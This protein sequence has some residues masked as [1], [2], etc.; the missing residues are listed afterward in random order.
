MS[1]FRGRNPLRRFVRSRSGNFAAVAALLAVPLV[2]GAGVALDVSTI[3][4]VK[5]DLQQSLDSAALAVARKGPD[6]SERQAMEVATSFLSGNFANDYSNLKMARN[7]SSV[8]VT[9]TVNAGIAFG[10]LFGYDDVPVTVSS[11][12]DIAYT[13]YEIGLVLDTTGSMAG[14]KLRAMKGA[15]LGLIEDLSKQVSDAD[16]LKFALV[17]FATFVNVGPQYG[18]SFDDKGKIIKASAAD[19][20]DV[21]GKSTIPQLELL[22][23][24]SRFEVFHRLGREWAGCVETRQPS[25]KGAHDVADTPATRGDKAS[26]FVPAFAIDEPDD[27]GYRNSYIRSGVDPLDK[28]PRAKARKLAK[29]GLGDLLAQVGLGGFAGAAGGPGA[30]D[31]RHGKGPNDGCTVQPISPLTNDYGELKRKVDALRASGT[32]NIMEGV[33]WGMR[34]L[35]PGEPF[36]Q[37]RDDAPGVEKIMI[38]LTDGANNFGTR[39]VSLGSSYS[40]FGYLVDGRL[41]VSAGGSAVTNRLMNEKTLAACTNAKK[42]GIELYTIRLEEPDVQTGTMLKRCAS[43]REHFFD[44]PSRSQLDEVFDG[45]RDSIVRLRLSS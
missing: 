30:T 27:R 6:I 41:G 10:G 1:I 11:S 29:Y 25:K 4:R 28:S 24:I 36:T 31:Y 42:D 33:A 5:S 17:P 15:V 21:E 16:K 18:P 37:G 35:S 39:S 9:A 3:T 38:V 43:S 12:A 26:Y 45:I 2:V 19:W 23:G 32:T 40:S 44:A 20:L 34:V 7:G 14:G 22:P 13:S 8:K